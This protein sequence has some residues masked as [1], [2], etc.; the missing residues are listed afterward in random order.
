MLLGLNKNKFLSLIL[1]CSLLIYE[2]FI[3]RSLI[4]NTILVFLIICF[5][6]FFFT[7]KRITKTNF[8][9]YAIALFLILTLLMIRLMLINSEYI[10]ASIFETIILI[11]SLC[12]FFLLD[13][14]SILTQ[15]L[16]FWE[17]IVVSIAYITIIAALFS[18]FNLIEWREIIMGEYP[19]EFNPFLG[20]V[21]HGIF[22]KRPSFYFAEP[23]YIGFFLGL[24]A[25][26]LYSTKNT[27][28]FNLIIIFIACIITG[29]KTAW[30]GLFAVAF[31]FLILNLVRI[32]NIKFISFLA[33]CIFITSFLIL[34][35]SSNRTLEIT[36][37]SLMDR[38]GKILSSLDLIKQNFTISNFIFGQGSTFIQKKAEMGE[39]NAFLKLLVEQGLIS[40]IILILIIYFLLRKKPYLLF[41]VLITL[42][43]VVILYTPYFFFNIAIIYFVT[44]KQINEKY[45]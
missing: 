3:F 31:F 15:T 8:I 11:Y 33:L 41:Y 9:Y 19:V 6:F 44:K 14:E 38:Q 23:S 42:N 29:A 24:N 26:F 45:Q 28:K 13:K 1:L 40:F 10:A 12:Y 43:A 22:F 21:H 20:M 30:I 4:T 7:S 17:K 32:K 34:I 35:I 18:N 16:F 39:S 27:S 36:D 37:A 5:S 25:L 2:P